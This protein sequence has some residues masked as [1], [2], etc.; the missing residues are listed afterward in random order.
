MK[1]PHGGGY[2][3]MQLLNGVVYVSASNPIIPPAMPGQ[4]LTVGSLTLD[5]DGIHFDVAAVLADNALAL[6]I[7]PSI[8]GAANPAFNTMVQFG[9]GG[10][11]SLTDPHSLA[12][13]TSGGVVLDSQADGKLVLR[14]PALA[15]PSAC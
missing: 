9:V 4:A 10:Y 2:D 5:A 14:T 12:I 15:K 6:D 1:P 11:P 8:G 7:T 3:D 13:D